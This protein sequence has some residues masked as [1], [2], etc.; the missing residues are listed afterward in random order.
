MRVRWENERGPGPWTTVYNVGGTGQGSNRGA[1]E[2]ERIERHGDKVWIF[3]DRDLDTGVARH[4]KLT[5]R[6][7]VHYSESAPAGLPDTLAANSV[8]LTEIVQARNGS[9]CTSNGQ[10]CRIVRL[11]LNPVIRGGTEYDGPSDGETVSVSYW[12][13]YEESDNLRAAGEWHSVPH[14]AE[15][16]RIVADPVGTTPTLSVADAEGR[17]G[18][19]PAIRF[20]VRLSPAAAGEVTVRYY[21]SSGTAQ[22]ADYANVTGTLIFA[23]GEWR[24]IVEVPIVDDAEE[25]S[26]ET[27]FFH[28]FEAR[29]AQIG[30]DRATG[31]ILNREDEAPG[32]SATGSDTD[33]ESAEDDPAEDDAAEDDPAEDDPAE[34]QPGR[35]GSGRG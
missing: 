32:D 31:T 33:R 8:N 23:P 1:P 12:K 29:G 25:D 19:N 6:F 14:V 28:L 24:K 10:A 15:F 9:A 3:F 22:R 2:V 20:A 26:G 7:G 11:T 17:E 18:T 35:G 30:D 13:S 16:S 21:T 4:N 5:P 27:F 34:G